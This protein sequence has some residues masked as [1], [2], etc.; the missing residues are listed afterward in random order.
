MF[1]KDL[2]KSYIHNAR[3][4][5]VLAKITQ[6]PSRPKP[7]RPVDQIYML[8]G[9]QLNQTKLIS[10]YLKNRTVVFVGDGDCMS[11]SLGLLAKEIQDI[12]GPA[13]MHVF[14][15]DERLVK[16]INETAEYFGLKTRLEA[17]WY[18]I[19][20]PIPK[21]YAGR[22]DVFYTNPPYSSNNEGWSG[23]IF[24]ARCM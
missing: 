17:H 5:D 8:P 14:D 15:F 19:R 9:S 6:H 23:I 21:K 2:S 3:E 7:I 22:S 16:F 20:E 18:N 1:F 24:L 4:Y 12:E 13:H 11:L 10:D